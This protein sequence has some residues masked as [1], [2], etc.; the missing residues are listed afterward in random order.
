MLFS[1][2]FWFVFSNLFVYCLFIIIIF[3]ALL[4]KIVCVFIYSLKVI[5]CNIRTL[6]HK[7]NIRV[8]LKE[9]SQFRQKVVEFQIGRDYLL[10]VCCCAY[11]G[12]KSTICC[13]ELTRIAMRVHLKR[14]LIQS[15]ELPLQLAIHYF[16]LGCLDNCTHRKETSSIR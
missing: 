16:K 1:Y 6:C 4:N 12:G 5:L 15:Y 14:I 10:K 9:A 13:F 8:A 11:I 7:T 2:E 3:S